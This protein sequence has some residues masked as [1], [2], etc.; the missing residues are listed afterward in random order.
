VDILEQ[1]DPQAILVLLA[2]IFA[3][4]KAFFEQKKKVA[5]EKS[6]GE[7]TDFDPFEAYEEELARQRKALEVEISPP[8]I[9]PPLT[10]TT[11][12]LTN[13]TPPPPLPSNPVGPRLSAAEKQALAN[14]N[15]KSKKHS[16]KTKDSTRSRVY[17]HLS[18]PTAAREALLL[19]EVLGPPKA[20]QNQR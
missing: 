1:L 14:L 10:E 13:T 18:S 2:V 4:V 20:L 15:L 11:P 3:A 19:A 6:V 17:R 7:E 5:T 9:P 16:K 8:T 12:P